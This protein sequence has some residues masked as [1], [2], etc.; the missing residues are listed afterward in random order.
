[1][2]IKTQK[3]IMKHKKKLSIY[4]I[5]IL[6]LSLRLSMLSQGKEIKL[7]IPKQIPQR[8]SIAL[9]QVKAG[10]IYLPNEIRLKHID[11]SRK[12]NY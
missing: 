2:H 4:L 1:M 12:R 8:L 7:L 5:I 3:K 10:N 9:T 11:F 6:Q